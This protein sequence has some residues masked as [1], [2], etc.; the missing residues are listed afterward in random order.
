MACFT[1]EFIIAKDTPI[2]NQYQA[3]FF[4]RRTVILAKNWPGDEAKHLHDPHHSRW[5]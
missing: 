5:C 3:L 1:D 2:Y 4:A